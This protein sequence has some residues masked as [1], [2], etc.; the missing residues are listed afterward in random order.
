[1]RLIPVNKNDIAWIP[2]PIVLISNYL[3]SYN[4]KSSVGTNSVIRYA[5]QQHIID[6]QAILS[7]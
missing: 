6:H 3:F 1:M 2:R 7:H 4:N 5:I